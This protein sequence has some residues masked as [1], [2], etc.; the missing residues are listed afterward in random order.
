MTVLEARFM[1]QLRLFGE[2]SFSPDIQKDWTERRDF[3]AQMAVLNPEIANF[4]QIPG[5]NQAG[6]IDQMDLTLDAR[7]VY[8]MFGRTHPTAIV[9]IGESGNEFGARVHDMFP[10]GTLRYFEIRKKEA[11]EKAGIDPDS[12][13]NTIRA[14]SYSK[15]KEM[16]F[17][18]PH[19][20]GEVEVLLIDDVI[21][22]GNVAASVGEALIKKGAKIVGVGAQMS[23]D[24]QGG[25]QTVADR[26]QT[27]T[28]AGIRFQGIEFDEKSGEDRPIL[29]PVEKAIK[30]VFM[31]P[32]SE[33]AGRYVGSFDSMRDIDLS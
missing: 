26:L 10:A 5:M 1:D 11:L 2:V 22:N 21:A 25:L 18:I 3:A 6:E 31:T 28:W 20:E 7:L 32:Q 24:Y 4:I 17:V 19:L 27:V 23:K 16:D 12:Y 13:G 8:A 9:S 30:P 15:K 29:V 33:W 14:Y